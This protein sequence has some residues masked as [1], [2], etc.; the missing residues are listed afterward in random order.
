VKLLDTSV[1]VD[2]LRGAPDAVALLDRLCAEGQALAASELVR[3]ELLA[4]VRETERE[5]L[6]GFFGAV[7]WLTVEE[8]I[9]R[10]G[11]LLARGHRAAH[12]GIDDVDYLIA[13]TAIAADADL[14]TTNVRHFPMLP[15]LTAAY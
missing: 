9:T 10:I 3:F 8:E 6:E 14:L 4:G 11:G 13:A 5:A 15:G 2:H 1:A 12:S 7:R